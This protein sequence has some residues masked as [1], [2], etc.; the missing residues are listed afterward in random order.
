MTPTRV[1]AEVMSV[2]SHDEQRLSPVATTPA[3]LPTA[4]GNVELWVDDRPDRLV[5]IAQGTYVRPS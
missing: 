4:L 2:S 1:G 5:A 3:V